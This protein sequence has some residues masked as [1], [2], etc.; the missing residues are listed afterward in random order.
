[1]PYAGEHREGQRKALTTT[2]ARGPIDLGARG[3][4]ETPIIIDNGSQP[5]RSALSAGEGGE[6]RAHSVSAPRSGMS[7][8]DSAEHGPDRGRSSEP[9]RVVMASN[10]ARCRQ[11]V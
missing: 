10:A 6:E 5:L 11:A 9:A 3:R 2:R 8:I 1:R 7:S 4:Q